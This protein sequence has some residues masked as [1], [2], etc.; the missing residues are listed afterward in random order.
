LI[1]LLLPLQDRLSRSE[2]LM[3]DW[4]RAWNAGDLE[5]ER[6]AAEELFRMTPQMNGALA[7]MTAVH[8][9]RPAEALVRYA[10]YD[11]DDPC[12][13]GFVIPWNSLMSAHHMLGDFDAELEVA[14]RARELHP[15]SFSI[16]DSEIRALAAQG[17]VELVDSLLNVAS[18]LPPNPAYSFGLRWVWAAREFKAHGYRDAYRNAAERAVTWYQNRPPD[19]A[20][21][22]NLARSLYHAER[23]EEAYPIFDSLVAVNP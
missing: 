3:L 14:R 7:G 16:L 18:T 15:E 5:A 4:T 22:Y 10:A 6:R 23:F 11:W 1:N 13:Q 20:S 12:A 8:N 19:L 17:E 2:R 21:P 9:N